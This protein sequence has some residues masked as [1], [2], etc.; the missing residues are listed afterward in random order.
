MEGSLGSYDSGFLN[1]GLDN[2]EVFFTFI[3]F[4]LAFVFI[5]NYT[6]EK[7]FNNLKPMIIVFSIPSLLIGFI[8]ASD[9]GRHPYDNPFFLVLGYMITVWLLSMIL[10]YLLHFLYSIT[11]KILWKN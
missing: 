2:F 8:I 5:V 3:K 4:F 9:I 7:G 11:T 6:A 10:G 1:S